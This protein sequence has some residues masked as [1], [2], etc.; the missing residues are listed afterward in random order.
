LLETRAAMAFVGCEMVEA[1]QSETGLE[2]YPFLSQYLL[3]NPAP[4]DQLDPRW[5]KIIL[6]IIAAHAADHPPPKVPARDL[7]F[8]V[9]QEIFF[10]GLSLRQA[11]ATLVKDTGASKRA[12]AQAHIKFGEHGVRRKT[13]QTG[14]HLSRAFSRC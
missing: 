7:A 10:Y 5:R 12:V 13:S 4:L 2:A 1:S 6:G 8:L 14:S 9:D 11:R 3:R